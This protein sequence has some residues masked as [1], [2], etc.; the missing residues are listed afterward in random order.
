[1]LQKNSLHFRSVFPPSHEGPRA[2][3]GGAAGM[4]G[5]WGVVSGAPRSALHLTAHLSQL[6]DRPPP[7]GQALPLLPDLP[8]PGVEEGG[9]QGTR[10]EGPCKGRGRACATAQPHHP[11][12]APQDPAGHSD[13]SSPLWSL[14]ADMTRREGSPG[15]QQHA[16]THPASFRARSLGRP[17][18]AS[19]H[20]PPQHPADALARAHL[21]TLCF[22]PQLPRLT[23]TGL[24]GCPQG[25]LSQL[26]GDGC[27]TPG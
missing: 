21:T 18:A 3:R 22:E 27:V 9:H 19:G 26:A 16:L 1:M 23:W 2:S 20:P 10:Q 14:R 5:L 15:A 12:P 13:S 24:R 7:P 4:R 6:S 8:D 25:H 17:T 11:H